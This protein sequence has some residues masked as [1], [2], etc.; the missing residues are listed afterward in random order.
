MTKSTQKMK[1]AIKVVVVF[2]ALAGYT[3]AKGNLSSRSEKIT[4]STSE[5][6][7]PIKV[8]TMVTSQI[9]E[10]IKS[11][12]WTLTDEAIFIDP[13]IAKEVIPLCRSLD[14]EVR[15]LSL[16]VLAGIPEQ[17]ARDC[18]LD[19]LHDKDINVRSVASRLLKNNYSVQDVTKLHAELAANQ[20][21]YVREQIL[22][23]LGLIG[24]PIS[25]QFLAEHAKLEDDVHALHAL[26]LAMVKLKDGVQR[27]IYA[28]KL[29]DPD[30]TTRVLALQDYKYIQDKDFLPLIQP[31]LADES[32][33]LNVAPSDSKFYIRIC[34]VAVNV[35]DI[36]LQHPFTFEI[37]EAKFY[38]EQERREAAKIIQSLQ[39]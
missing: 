23:V 33:G 28:R 6:Q 22:L 21:E 7:K 12:D 8:S 37:A 14:P 16:F 19:A 35:L 13:N 26:H 25:N 32:K 20:D 2:I 29:Q 17:G 24:D 15:E 30:A 27:G 1:S 39:H 11:K 31:L 36:V 38:S 3:E 34:D 5:Q 18:I 10:Q 9:V 4:S